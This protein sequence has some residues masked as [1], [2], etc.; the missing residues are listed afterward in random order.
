MSFRKEIFTER[1]ADGPDNNNNDCNTDRTVSQKICAPEGYKVF[2]WEGPL[3]V[4]TSSQSRMLGMVPDP[5]NASCVIVSFLLKGQG[6]DN[7]PFGLKACKES[8]WY[9]YTINLHAYTTQMQ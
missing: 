1:R 3:S 7:Y 5:Q 6:Y 8:A 4:D 9:K 2:G